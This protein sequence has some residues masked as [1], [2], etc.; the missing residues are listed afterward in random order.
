MVLGIKF[1]PF[2]ISTHHPSNT[3]PW[4]CLTTNFCS[5][6]VQA[7]L[8]VIIPGG[9]GAVCLS[10]FNVHRTAQQPCCALVQVEYY[11]VCDDT[12]LGRLIK[13]VFRTAGPSCVMKCKGGAMCQIGRAHV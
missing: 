2:D 1:L 6:L 8:F 3:V 4:S 10:K 7:F 13:G 11:C 9:P 5:P 12:L